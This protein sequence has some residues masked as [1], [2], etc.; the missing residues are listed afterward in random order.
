MGRAGEP[1]FRRDGRRR[2]TLE[3]PRRLSADESATEFGLFGYARWTSADP[4]IREMR[5]QNEGGH[6]ARL[7][8][9]G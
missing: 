8:R 5:A 1:W 3:D 9:P 6:V 4:R 2:I 7:R